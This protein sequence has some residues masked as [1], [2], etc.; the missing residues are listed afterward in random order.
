MQKI[1]YYLLFTNIG[2]SSPYMSEDGW[3][4]DTGG[5]YRQELF[6]AVLYAALVDGEERRSDLVDGLGQA[7][8]VVTVACRGRKCTTL[9]LQAGG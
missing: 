9:L 4:E 8:N 3:Q 5:S 1:N 2:C 6:E 7:V